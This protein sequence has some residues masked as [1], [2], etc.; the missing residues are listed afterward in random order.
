MDNIISI[1]NL[2]GT[3]GLLGFV[4]NIANGNKKKVSYES[5]DRYKKDAEEKFR[6]KEV[7]V[8]LHTQTQKDIEEIKVNTKCIPAIKLGMDLLLQ[9]NGTKND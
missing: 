3:L 6:G 4:W 2:T 1:I 7:C 5:F 8:V 9:K